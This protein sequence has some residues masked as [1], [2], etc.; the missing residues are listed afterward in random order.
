MAP[1]APL[2]GNLVIQK[3]ITAVLG[4]TNTGKTHYA[5]ERMSAHST[6]MIGLPLRLLAREVY[7]KMVERKG[8]RLVALVT[9]E[10]KIVPKGARYWVCTVEAMPLE[11]EVSFLAIDEVQLAADPERG[12]VFTERL[13]HAR[14][15][16]ETLFLGSDTMR[17]ILKRLVDDIDFVGRERFSQL[18]FVGHKKATRLPRRTA[19]VGFSADNV[20]SI[21][22][23]IRR[24][25]GGAAIVMG[26]LSPRTR[27]AQ[28][29]L[30]NN[31]EVD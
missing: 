26:A 9:G 6:G 17:P 29:E 28:A 30:Y 23:L 31:G 14:G 11:R 1:K 16:H 2:P 20:Y 13:L 3:P 22:E 18:D 27:N 7:D 5:L 15:V 21:A 19:I 24:Q 25:R 8:E 12:R 4:P 10:E